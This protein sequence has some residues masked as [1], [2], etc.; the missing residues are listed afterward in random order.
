MKTL[1]Y[2]YLMKNLATKIITLITLAAFTLSQFAWADSN[3]RITQAEANGVGAQI[4]DELAAGQAAANVTEVDAGSI[5]A[6]IANAHMNSLP[7]KVKKDVFEATEMAYHRMGVDVGSHNCGVNDVIR[8]ELNRKNYSTQLVWT[9]NIN[10]GI[11]HNFFLL[12]INGVYWLIDAQWQQYL[13][14][15]SHD[16]ENKV[17]IVRAFDKFTSFDP[18]MLRSGLRACGVPRGRLRIWVLAIQKTYVELFP[19]PQLVKV[20]SAV[21]G[22]PAAGSA[23]GREMDITISTP[24]VEMVSEA[25]PAAGSGASTAQSAADTVPAT[26]ESRT[27]QQ[28]PL[29]IPEPFI[30]VKGQ[31]A[32]VRCAWKGQLQCRNYRFA[33]EFYTDVDDLE[34]KEEEAGCYLKF[35]LAGELV[36]EIKWLRGKE[37]ILDELDVFDEQFRGQ[38]ALVRLADVMMIIFLRDLLQS[39]SNIS[40]LQTTEV[41]RPWNSKPSPGIFRMLEKIYLQ[42]DF[43]LIREWADALEDG[44]AQIQKGTHI[45]DFNV[46]HLVL[47]RN[48]PAKTKSQSRMELILL[49]EDGRAAEQEDIYSYLAQRPK[50]LVIQ[51]RN[52]LELKQPSATIRDKTF[53]LWIG[54]ISYKMQQDSSKVSGLLEQIKVF[55]SVPWLPDYVACGFSAAGSAGGR[56]IA[57]AGAFGQAQDEQLAQ[58]I[59]ERFP[60]RAVVV[61]GGGFKNQEYIKNILSS[62]GFDQVGFV[63]SSADVTPIVNQFI[64][65]GC[66]VLIIDIDKRTVS[67]NVSN[68][69][70][71]TVPESM[72]W[73]GE[74]KTMDDAIR[75][76]LQLVSDA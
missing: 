5:V 26:T 22:A 62:W 35:Y 31:E 36:A 74:E 24:G 14:V 65:Q 16:S 13:P 54:G 41:M 76:Y 55:P 4:E 42:P 21:S 43:G 30:F 3:I 49:T 27:T 47:V 75:G 32:L 9:V 46:P 8:Y 72:S 51:L 53:R 60:R 56:E 25:P 20:Q 37:P 69:Q 52:L 28:T 44:S 33:I 48:L 38:E 29:Q 11:G 71:I 45:G 23:G 39:N 50:E 67:G 1:G 17:L 57:I 68:L 6:N 58:T 64:Q 10:R 73:Q 2:F 19:E 59:K 7:A 63:G 66:F 34:I 70:S 12:E 40:D 18:E 61:K 15:Q